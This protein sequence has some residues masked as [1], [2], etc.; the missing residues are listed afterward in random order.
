MVHLTISKT[1]MYC[2][3]GKSLR[4]RRKDNQRFDNVITMLSKS[5]VNIHKWANNSISPGCDTSGDDTTCK[6]SSETQCLIGLRH[7][8][9][10]SLSILHHTLL[11][12]RNHSLTVATIRIDCLHPT[13][14]YLEE[15]VL[16]SSPAI[17]IYKQELPVRH[18]ILVC[19]YYKETWRRSG[20]HVRLIHDSSGLEPYV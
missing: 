6:I 14:Q 12:F 7:F 5:P 9:A 8:Y 4:F 19:P 15:Y 1:C 11:N 3:V 17:Y 13:R 20:D 10:E 2:V 16:F 18:Q